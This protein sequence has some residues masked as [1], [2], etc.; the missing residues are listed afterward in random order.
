MCP[1][2]KIETHSNHLK[3]GFKI[4]T[5]HYDREFATVQKLIE[6]VWS[7]PMVNL[8]IIN[9]HVSQNRSNNAGSN[10][11]TPPGTV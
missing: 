1:Q 6:E 4:I 8:K 5:V 2:K 3:G 10:E 7:V 11:T 9:E